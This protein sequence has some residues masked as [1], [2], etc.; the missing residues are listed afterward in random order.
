[1]LD[2]LSTLACIHTRMLVPRRNDQNVL[3]CKWIYKVKLD[4][5][6]KINRQKARL[7][8]NDMRQLNGMHY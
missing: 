1:M 6:R 2:E 7:V 8:L 3:A 5:A 4:D